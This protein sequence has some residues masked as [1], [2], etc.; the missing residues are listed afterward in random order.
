MGWGFCG[1]VVVGL[2]FDGDQA[3]A[4]QCGGNEEVKMGDFTLVV[5]TRI[6]RRLLAEAVPYG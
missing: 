5:G 4:C 3:A 6:I 1:R 2:W